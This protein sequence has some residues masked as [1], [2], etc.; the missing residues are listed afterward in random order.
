MPEPTQIN[1]QAGD[2][3]LLVGTVKGAFIFRSDGAREKWD[4]AG[5]YFPGRS[6]YAMN[7]DGRNGRQRL[8]AAVN[9]SF[10][11]SFLSSSNDFGR[12]WSDPEAYN[13]KFPE[14]SEVSLKQIWQIVPGNTSEPDTL[15]CGVEPAALFKSTDAGETWSLERGL[16]DHPHRTQWMPGGGGLCLHT[17]LPDPSN[18]QRIFVAISTGGVYRTDDGGK[19]WEPR[20]KGIFVKFLPP[21]QQYPEW[22]QC[23]HKVVSHPANPDRMFLQH[24]WGVYRSDDAGDSW[25]DIG[26]GLPS[27]FGFALEIDPHDANTVFI[28]PIESDEFRCTPEAK[29]RVYRTR[30]AGESWEPLTEGLPQEDA[31]ETILRDSLKADANDPTGLYFGT[32][33]GKLFGSNNG[34]D[35]WTAISEGLPAITCVKTAKIN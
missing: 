24:H 32:R 18:D 9:S 17:I 23:V 30:N 5:P 34:G 16:F 22:G 3:L 27:D 11:G 31:F 14:G 6:V 20:N 29:L 12:T 26:K 35:S 10:W 13:I 8:W 19:N 2:T 25:T 1:A 21:G 7:F 33:N 4:V 15:Y 28:I